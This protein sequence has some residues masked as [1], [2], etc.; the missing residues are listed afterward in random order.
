MEP[1]WVKHLTPHFGSKF[2][3]LLPNI[4]LHCTKVEAKVPLMFFFI[5]IYSDPGMDRHFLLFV[6]VVASQLLTSRAQFY[7]T[8]LA[9]IYEFS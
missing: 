2:L 9:L 3:V 8:F 5:S 4:R 7:K 1:A 6:V